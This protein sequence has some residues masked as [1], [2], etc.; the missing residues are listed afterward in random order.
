MSKHHF[1][2]FDI[3]A[4]SGRAV[5]GTLEEKHFQMEEIH[6]FANPLIE[7]N[8]KYYW[9][10]YQLYQSLIESLSVCADRGLS[11]QSVGIDTW[12]V[13]FG[14]VAADGTLLGLPRA[15]R[16][17][18]TEG[19]PEAFFREVMP[20][21]E[22]YRRTG[23]QI[24]PFNSLYQFYQARREHFAPLEQASRI[25]FVP[26]LLSY[27][28]TGRMVCERTIAS[29]SQ[30]L[31]P[32]T[33]RFDAKLLSAVGLTAS[34]VGEP[35]EPGVCVGTLSPVLAR[36]TGIGEVPVVAVAGHDTASAIVAVPAET[37]HF[38]YM[39]SGTWS[40]MG[41]ESE[42]P[43][44]TEESSR[45]NFT[46]E[47]GIEGT[48]RFLKNI[49]GMWILER[50]RAEW[51]RQGH[52]YSYAALEQMAQESRCAARIQPDDPLFANPER[53]T[54]AILRYCA[55]HGQ[56]RPVSPADFVRC[57]F[58]SLA[59]RY[60]EVLRMLSS[61]SSFPIRQLHVIG[62]GSQ[63]RL[64]NQLTANAI[65]LPVVAGPSEA[66]AIG[67]CLVQ[68]KSAGLVADRWEMRRLVRE[69]FPLTTYLPE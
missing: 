12:G 9:D 20:R 50:C 46:N 3:G 19:V 30:L 1:L 60:G 29:T 26:D 21:E 35:V 43:I 38:A 52:D 65:G 57:I 62:G 11:I 32:H 39:N 7:W 45:C 59:D 61:M 44:V 56:P 36:R 13:D 5:V 40:L 16:D 64:L 24:L 67:N 27:M 55:Q 22:V 53:M 63:N 31:D 69:S 28:L 15:Y 58:Y 6:R 33:G 14:C 17:P 68:A 23:I 49:T 37:P 34:Q 51:K 54:E 47:G 2:A 8:G 18:Y 42:A 41:I 66:T 10:V 25:L 4:T 48:T